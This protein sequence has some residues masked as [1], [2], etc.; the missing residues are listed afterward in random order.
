MDFVAINNNGKLYIQVAETLK[1]TD[2]RE[3]RALKK[4]DDN[5]EKIILTADKIPSGNEEG[6][7]ICNVLDWLLDK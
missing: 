6:I 5:Y 1:G 3:L 7:K 2:E 4:I